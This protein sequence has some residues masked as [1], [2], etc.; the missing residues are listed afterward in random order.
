VVA[1]A[2]E[3]LRKNLPKDF[4]LSLINLG[5]SN[6]H[7]AGLPRGLRSI[8]RLFAPA[9]SAKR[10]LEGADGN[11]AGQADPAPLAAERGTGGSAKI[12]TDG[13]PESGQ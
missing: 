9:S 13:Q 7:D 4:D 10:P 8:S 12:G 1:L 3:L 2:A 6:F 11:A 5:V